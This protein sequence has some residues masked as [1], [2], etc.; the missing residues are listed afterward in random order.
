MNGQYTQFRIDIWNSVRE[1]TPR[2]CRMVVHRCLDR[3]DY[4]LRLME[5]NDFDLMED[6]CFDYIQQSIS[7]MCTHHVY[8]AR[9]N[10]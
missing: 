1:R 4:D 2:V 6:F 10:V 8:S 3:T 9:M 5:I 7:L